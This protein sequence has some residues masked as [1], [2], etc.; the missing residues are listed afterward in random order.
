MFYILLQGDAVSPPE[1]AYVMTFDR[2]PLAESET[3]SFHVCGFKLV[4]SLSLVWLSADRLLLQFA[5]FCHLC[6]LL[7]SENS[8]KHM[9]FL[10]RHKPINNLA[11]IESTGLMR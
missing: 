1:S 4:V 9:M 6:G 2:D 11:E 7:S 5:L 10:E 8:V 3:N